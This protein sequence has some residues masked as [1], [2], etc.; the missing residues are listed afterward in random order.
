MSSKGRKFYSIPGGRETGWI[1]KAV[2]GNYVYPEFD[3]IICAN[4]E[5]ALGA[6]N[7]LE[8]RRAVLIAG[9]DETAEALEKVRTGEIACTIRQPPDLLV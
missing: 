2:G 1:K 9:I 4:D 5:M 6:V 8:V 7:A 3:A